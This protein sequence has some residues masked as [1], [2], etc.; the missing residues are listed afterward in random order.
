K[1]SIPARNKDYYSV[2]KTVNLKVYDI[3]GREI[4]TLVNE[5][6]NPG[7]YEVTFDGNGITSGVYFYR[8]TAGDFI[9]TKKMILIK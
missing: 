8:L 5:K 9:E 2:L 7:N 3:L 6:Q 4:A 1:Y